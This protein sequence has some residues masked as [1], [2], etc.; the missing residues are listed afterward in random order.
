RG[1]SSSATAR[2]GR[3]RARRWPRRRRPR[4]ACSRSPCPCLRSRS[5]SHARR[6]QGAPVRFGRMTSRLGYELVVVA[7]ILVVA[8]TLTAT[9]LGRA[10]RRL[11]AGV[12]ALLGGVAV[13]AWIVFAFV[14]KSDAAFA[15]VALT[16]CA[17]AAAGALALRAAI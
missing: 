2:P 16:G 14:R 8:V 11:V 10:P 9:A 3:S 1:R 5:C 17:V 12:T 13:A 7:G 15:A 4:S 6:D